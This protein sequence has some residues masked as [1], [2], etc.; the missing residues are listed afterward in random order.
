MA[1]FLFCFLGYSVTDSDQHK[2]A[3]FVL[4]CLLHIPTKICVS[5]ANQIF[6]EPLG[7]VIGS[8]KSK[9]LL[10]QLCKNVT[11]LNR[12]VQLGCLLGI[13]EWTDM[14]QQKC[15]LPDSAIQDL[16]PDAEELFG[17]VN[18]EQVR[19]SFVHNLF[20]IFSDLYLFL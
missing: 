8:S 17:E 10:V 14:I 5:L 13:P 1:S 2:A 3:M 15:Q 18:P 9:Q 11:E 20:K 7:Q 4:Q 16:P 12:L 6:L 19:E